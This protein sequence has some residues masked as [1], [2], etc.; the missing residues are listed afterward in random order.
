MALTRVTSGVLG[1]N[2]VSAEKLANGSITSRTLGNNSIELK[3]L[4]SSANFTGSI[5]TVQ[6]N[7]T[8]NNIQFTANLNTTSSNISS[9]TANVNIVSS[10]VSGVAAN[11]IQNKAN[12][13]TALDNV[14]QIVANL[15]IVSSNVDNITGDDATNFTVNKTFEQNVIVQ[16]N[17]IV[18]GS[19]VDLGVGT[20]T[21]DDNFIV[22]SANL[23]GTPATDSGI[24]INRGNEGNTFIGDHVGDEGVVFALTQSPHDNTTIAIQEY[25]DVHANAFHAESAMNFSR[26][27]L[28]HVDDESTGIVIDTTNNHIK[29]VASGAEEGNISAD[30]DML[31]V[32]D[33]IPGNAVIAPTVFAGGLDVKANL[34]D[35]S[36]NA[37]GISQN[38][39]A[40]V[41]QLTANLNVVNQNVDSGVGLVKKVNTATSTGSSNVFF[42]AVPS[43]TQHPS[44]LEKVNVFL[45]GVRQTPDSLTGSNNDFVYNSADASVTITDPNL[46]SGLTVII[47]ALCPRP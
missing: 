38:L 35:L 18:V 4:S 26:V 33:F 37:E 39:Q 24:I 8:A 23:T 15:D 22:V 45:D 2:A 6:S 11:T 20:A 1:S 3:H 36:S 29:F 34:N 31:I 40:N 9:I 16:G 25:L 30:G 7:L 32:R 28:G 5:N 47:D 10:N 19:Q 43:A 46:P 17:L 13:D 27:H 41:I 14:V 21:I 12:V 42:V 44:D